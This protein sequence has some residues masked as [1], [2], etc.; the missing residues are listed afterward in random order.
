[1]G[2]LKVRYPSGQWS[3]ILGS[4]FD[5]ANTVRWNSAWGQVAG[6]SMSGG[7]VV[8]AANTILGQVSNVPTVAGRRYRFQ[9]YIRAMTSGGNGAFDTVL[10]VD[11]AGNID[12]WATN[13]TAYGNTLLSWLV[14]GDGNT[15]TYA[16]Q[17]GTVSGSAV[18]AYVDAA[19]WVLLEDIGPVT[20]ASIAPPT[21]GP[22][23]VA[24]GNAL[25]IVAMGALDTTVGAMSASTQYRLTTGL[26]CFTAAGRRY[27]ITFVIRA[28]ST[29][30]NNYVVATCWRDGAG[31]YPTM[32]D[33]YQGVIN[34]GYQQLNAQW[35]FD[36]DDLTHTWD[37]YLQTGAASV[38]QAYPAPGGLHYI[39]DVGPN[40]SPALP[41]P[42]TNPPWTA[43]T[44]LNGWLAQGTSEVQPGYRKV[45]D[46]VQLKGAIT[47]GASAALNQTAFTLPAGFYNTTLTRVSMIGFGSNG[48]TFAAR[49]DLSNAGALA[50]QSIMGATLNGA[51]LQLNGVSW[52]V[53]VT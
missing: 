52:P 1:M 47:A 44:P 38:V 26:T 12:V 14:T 11:G 40:T 22:R 29:P 9:V 39:E 16:A 53:G 46:I 25:G 19:S 45:G 48:T 24:S 27:R 28:L 30:T 20:P 34:Y 50:V 51:I 31:Q 21:A 33:R 4:G 35:Y 2:T 42:A 10:K 43:I 18:T 49:G 37:V 13:V 15:H 41:I 8:I 23:V 17:V 36:G 7:T 32:G 6:G 5:A 3:A